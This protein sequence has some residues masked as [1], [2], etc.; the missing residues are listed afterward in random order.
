MEES[1]KNESTEHSK[2]NETQ[3]TEAAKT[4]DTVKAGET[5]EDTTPKGAGDSANNMENLMDM[6]EESFKRFQEGEVVTG[7]IISVGR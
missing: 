6:Y 3:E 4:G 2:Q 1:T 5:S 7:K